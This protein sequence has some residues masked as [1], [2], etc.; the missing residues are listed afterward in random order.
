M[1]YSKMRY[2]QSVPMA[3]PPTSP[4]LEARRELKRLAVGMMPV[5][6]NRDIVKATGANLNTLI[7]WRREAGIPSP[8]KTTA[9]DLTKVAKPINK[10]AQW[11]CTAWVIEHPRCSHKD[12]CASGTR[13]MNTCN[14]PEG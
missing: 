1:Y 12:R 3:K 6:T 4:E 13:C 8:T 11:P 14:C 9:P 5:K 2:V 10:G 7:A